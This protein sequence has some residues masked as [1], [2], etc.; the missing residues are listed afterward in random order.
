[1]LTL[2][3]SLFP[4]RRIATATALLLSGV[5][6]ASCSDDDEDNTP[7]SPEL[8]TF[9]QAGLFPEG[10]QYDAKNNSF[11]VSSLAT[12]NIGRVT[13]AGVYT[14]L[15]PGTTASGT[16]IITSAVGIN[17]DNSRNRVLVASSN[18]MAGN[19]ARLVSYNRDNGQLN[20]NV[21]LGVLTT[22][23]R[24]F[25]N[26]IAVDDQGN[27][28]VTDS[29][30]PYIYKV[31]PQ[32]VASVFLT[33]P[34]FAAAAGAFGLNGI[35]FHPDG[36]LLVARA[37]NG[38]LFKVPVTAP[39]SFTRVTTTGIDFTGADGLLLEDNNTLQAVVGGR[40]V[41]RLN[42][43]NNWTAATQTGTFTASQSVSP[44]TLARRAGA[45]SYV[46]YSRLSQMMVTPPPAEF[47]IGKVTF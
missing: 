34:Q 4:L 33:D 39:T 16:R 7:A 22:A 18:A 2:T 1:M 6:A 12:G 15:A 19:V 44:T 42:T 30:A 29:F 28:Y 26:D 24:H 47:T 36:Y 38:S 35:V 11:L 41:I 10:V 25:A 20:F 40:S 8:V 23:S 3:V 9:T 27:A 17:L 13:D 46:L 31:D 14:V 45:D 43:S 37:D 32:G 21:D 5:L